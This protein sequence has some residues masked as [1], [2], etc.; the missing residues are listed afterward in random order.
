M[1]INLDNLHC[2]WAGFLQ[3]WLGFGLRDQVVQSVKELLQQLAPDQH[4]S[5]ML[6]GKQAACDPAV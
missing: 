5:I 1:S 2:A 3:A 4:C 6:T